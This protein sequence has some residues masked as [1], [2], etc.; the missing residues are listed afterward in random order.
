MLRRLAIASTAATGNFGKWTP[1]LA[2]IDTI[3]DFLAGNDVMSDAVKIVQGNLVADGAKFAIVAS[4][5]NSFLVDKLVAGA[6]D[7]ITRHGAKPDDATLVWVPGAFEIP[8]AARRLAE[9]GDFDAIICL[10]AIV[11]G[12]TPHFE[13]VAN[14]TA[15]G[16]AEVGLQTGVPCIFGIVTADN[17]EQAIERCG[18]K[19]GNKGFDAAVTAIEMVNV[20]RQLSKSPKPRRTKGS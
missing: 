3:P 13:Y 8:V 17:L 9:S 15:T 14:A 2:I 20:L 16:I 11:R 7:A 12:A 19:A 6:L 18:T 10:G 5:F 4:R 1:S